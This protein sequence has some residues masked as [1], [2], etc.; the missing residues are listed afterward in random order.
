[1]TNAS[2][3]FIKR[4]LRKFF[5]RKGI[6]QVVV[7]DNGS[8]FTYGTT[9]PELASKNRL[10]QRLHRTKKYVVQ[11]LGRELGSSLEAAIA[12]AEPETF[13]EL[14]NATDSFFLNYCNAAHA[15]TRKSLVMEFNGRYLRVINLDSTSVQ[16]FR[17]NDGQPSNGTILGRIETRIFNLLDQ[18]D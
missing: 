12:T 18:S 3:Y 10:P 14:D 11:R 5:A 7:T 2:A 17:R 9:P 16:S 1:M 13:A 4:T 6:A 8:H 15:T